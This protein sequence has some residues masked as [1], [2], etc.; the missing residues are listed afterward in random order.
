MPTEHEQT[1]RAIAKIVRDT[2]SLT[3]SQRERKMSTNTIMDSQAH[4]FA[5]VAELMQPYL[6]EA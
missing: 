3:E 5:Q 1:L 2:Q 6:D 4:A